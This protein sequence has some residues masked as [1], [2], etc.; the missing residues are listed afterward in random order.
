MSRTIT[1]RVDA[2]K[3]NDYTQLTTIEKLNPRSTE[4][5]CGRRKK[6]KVINLPSIPRILRRLDLLPCRLFNE[7]G[8]D[9]CHGG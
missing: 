9:V 7:R 2:I 1:V 6:G 5:G 3:G 4:V 8:L